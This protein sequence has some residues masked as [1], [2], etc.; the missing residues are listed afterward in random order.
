MEEDAPATLK[1]AIDDVSWE[2]FQKRCTLYVIL[3]LK[4]K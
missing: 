4:E 1:M 3:A 2:L